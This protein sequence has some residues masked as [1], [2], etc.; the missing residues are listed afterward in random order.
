MLV[1]ISTCRV[2]A[3]YKA[4]LFKQLF[5]FISF[6]LFIYSPISFAQRDEIDSL[7][8]ILPSLKDTGRIDCMNELSVQYTRLLI[9][10]SAQYFEALAYNQSKAL[11]YIHGI[12]VSISNQSSIFEYF[13]N[14]FVKS[15]TLARESIGWFEK[16]INKNGIENA[17]NNLSFALFSQSKYDEAYQIAKRRYEKSVIAKDTTMMYDVLGTMGV[18]HYPGG[19]L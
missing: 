17:Y 8:K 16:I 9:R 6:Y 1:N 12:A 3:F 5:L 15:E 11:G 14:E 18:I 19:Q 10:D 2:F 4:A 7:K 13:D